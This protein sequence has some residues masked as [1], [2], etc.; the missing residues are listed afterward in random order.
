MASSAADAPVTIDVARLDAGAT[1][2][3][4]IYYTLDGS[5]PRMPDGSPNPNAIPFSAV[6]PPTIAHSVTMMSRLLDGEEWSPLSEA[7]FHIAELPLPGDLVISE[8]NAGP[9][10]PSAAE[11]EAGV[12]GGTEFE[13]VEVRNVSQKTLDLSGLQFTGGVQATVNPSD[14]VTLA[15]GLTALFVANRAS[16]MARYP[17]TQE[18]SIVAQ[19]EGRLSRAGERL[20]L[21]DHNG[22]LLVTLTYRKNDRWASLSDTG[23][24]LEFAGGADS[25]PENAALWR[26]SSAPGGTPGDAGVSTGSLNEWLAARGLNNASQTIPVS[27]LSALIHYALGEDDIKRGLR[28]RLPKIIATSADSA[29][30]EYERRAGASDLEFLF[31]H[32]SDL[33][34]WTV[35]PQPEELS[36]DAT[37]DGGERITLRAGVAN[38]TAN[39][40]R[41]AVQVK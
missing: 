8:I 10:D 3:G 36:V 39:Y 28:T 20:T 4:A 17:A 13:F 11:E 7:Y 6:N 35:E 38:R 29:T 9:A 22:Q 12:G 19:F 23:Q 31:E 24:T 1:F 26:L 33:Q 27:G 5:D 37:D 18:T 34:T 15:P 16:F 30:L 41:L 40:W 32:S 14:R 21:R 2:D 25:H